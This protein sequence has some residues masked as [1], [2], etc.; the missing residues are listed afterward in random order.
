[1][2]VMNESDVMVS[3]ET[4]DRVFSLVIRTFRIVLWI[5]L[6]DMDENPSV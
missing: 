2:S 1:M 4:A 3:V 5:N 6:V